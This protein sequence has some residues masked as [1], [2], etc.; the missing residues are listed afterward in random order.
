MIETCVFRSIGEIDRAAWNACFPGAIE[1]H[2]YLH[3]I[4]KSALDGFSWRYAAAFN[5]DTLIAV[6][7]AF[8]TDYALDT[9]LSGAGKKVVSGMRRVLPGALRLRLGAIGSPC[10]ETAGLGF[11]DCVSARDKPAIL[12]ALIRGFEADA[13]RAGCG[14]LAVK[15]AHSKMNEIWDESLVARG[16][17]SIPGLPIAVLPIDFD[18]LEGYLSRLSAGTRKDMRRKL[19]ALSQVRIEYRSDIADVLDEV[20]AIY[21]ETLKRAELQFEE[22]TP[23][24]FTN[25][26]AMMPAQAFF[27]LYYVAETL[28]GFNLLL[29]NHDTLLDKFFC[30]KAVEGK[31]SNLY[32][33]SW[34]TNIRLCLERGLK[35][36]Q[37]GQAGYENKVRLGSRLERTAMYFRHRNAFVSKAMHLAAPLFVPDPTFARAGQ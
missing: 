13:L 24:Y 7:P 25:V 26:L 14:L 10:T 8:L 19:R 17:R 5:G 16:Y 29:Q 32:F 12:D 18:T 34:F 11:A 1:T 2:A 35:R 31:K 27:V 33:L 37:S 30:M 23:S 6:A 4:E 22:L 28:V 20:V 21:N 3:A 36:Y 15:D 9:T